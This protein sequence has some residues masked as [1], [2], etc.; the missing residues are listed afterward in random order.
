MSDFKEVAE[1]ALKEWLANDEGVVRFGMTLKPEW[2]S[3]ASTGF[4]AGYE[5]AIKEN[6]E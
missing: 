3:A 2:V 1:M 5:A 6:Q 4:M